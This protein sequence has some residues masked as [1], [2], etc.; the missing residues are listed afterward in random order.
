MTGRPPGGPRPP[1]PE[2]GGGENL[3]ALPDQPKC[4]FCDGERT[5]L[6]NAFGPH[7]SV[8]TY[9]CHPC[10]SPFDFMRWGRAEG[11]D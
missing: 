8:S 7:A 10:H 9:W 11:K 3:K 2:E 1:T 6:M 5:E 4:P